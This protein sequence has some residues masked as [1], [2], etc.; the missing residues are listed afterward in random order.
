VAARTTSDDGTGPETAQGTFESFFAA[1]SDRLFGAMCVVTRDPGEAEELTQEAF[2][3]V[4]ER[5]ERVRTLDDP[6]GYLYRT[7]MNC[8]RMALRRQAVRRRL[9]IERATPDPFDAV[10]SR[11]TLDRALGGLSP[12][13]RAAVVLTELLGFPSDEAGRLLGVKPV[14]VRVLASQA[15]AAMRSSME[16]HDG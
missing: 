13:Q 8:F 15:Q 9:G 16:G 3:R 1:Q 14:T 2:V 7:A 12:R 6:V 5:W 4:W 10:E 11:A